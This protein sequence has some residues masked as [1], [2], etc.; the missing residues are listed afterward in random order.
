MARS[1]PC[2]RALWAVPLASAAF[3]ITI[4]LC[5]VDLAKRSGHIHPSIRTPPISLAG[6]HAPEYYLF[7]PGF[8][9][10][11]LLLGLCEELWWRAFSARLPSEGPERAALGLE[12]MRAQVRLGFFGLAL[13][14]VVPL[15]GWGGA[16]TLVHVGGSMAFFC[17]SLQHGYA[18]CA[19]LAAQCMAAHP[20]H[21]A[22]APW[23]W[24]AKA[25][26]LCNG[27]LSFVPAQL[28]HPGGTPQRPHAGGEEASELD[29]GGFGQ[30]WLVGSLIGYFTLFSVDMWVMGGEGR[31]EGKE[32]REKEEKEL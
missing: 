16:G 4:I 1:L 2:E 18:L 32:G 7:A 13:V 25:A 30:W 26:L 23:L 14:G 20:L 3:S 24:R 6:I 21:S 27:F 5:S 31:G 12:G 29:R 28:L 22:R 17:C 8:A 15:Q 19:A 9:A 11:A 10:M